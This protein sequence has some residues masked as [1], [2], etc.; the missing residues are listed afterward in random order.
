MSVA[1]YPANEAKEN[2]SRISF[3]CNKPITRW[4]I[5]AD[6]LFVSFHNKEKQHCHPGSHACPGKSIPGYFL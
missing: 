4:C 1:Q 6:L 5:A 3:A 2:S